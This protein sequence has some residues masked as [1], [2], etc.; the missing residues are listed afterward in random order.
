MKTVHALDRAAT[1]IGIVHGCLNRTTNYRP[2]ASQ[3]QCYASEFSA[4]INRVPRKNRLLYTDELR[5]ICGC[6]KNAARL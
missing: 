3:I 2:I 1:V 6:N 4:I 5:N